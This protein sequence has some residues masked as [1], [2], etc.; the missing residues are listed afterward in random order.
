MIRVVK[1]DGREQDWDREK[2]IRAALSAGADG[3]TAKWVAKEVEVACPDKIEIEDL[4]QRVIDTLPSEVSTS[5]SAYKSERD[6]IR[7]M[8]ETPDVQA[9]SDYILSSKYAHYDIEASTLEDWPTCWRR[10]L[11]MHKR[12]YPQMAEELETMYENFVA[13]KKVL[14]AMRSLQFGGKAIEVNNTRMY[15]CWFG[16]CDNIKFFHRLFFILLSGGGVGYSVQKHHVAKLPKVLHV[17]A[18]SVYWHKVEDTIEGWGRAGKALLESYFETGEYVEFDFSGI[19]PENAWL[20]TTGGRAPGHVPLKTALENVRRVLEAFAGEQLTTFAAHRIAC[21][22]A[23]GVLSGGIRRS[24]LIALFSFDDAEM[25]RCKATKDWFDVYPELKM[26]NNSVIL[27]R[28][29]VT[30]EEFHEIFDW[31]RKFGEPGFVF[32]NDLEYGGNPC[33]EIGLFPRLPRSF[34]AC[35]LVEINCATVESPEDFY[36]RCEAA[37]II[38]TC[39]AGYTNL[40]Y[41]GVKTEEVVIAESLIGVG[42]CGIMDN[43]ICRRSEILRAGASVVNQTN[44]RIAD[45]IGIPH[46]ARTTTMKPGGTASLFLGCIACGVHTH[47]CRR[48]FRLITANPNEPVFQWFQKHNPHMC[49]QKPDGDWVIR[50]PVQVP[51]TAIVQDDMTSC[52]FLD[53]VFMVYD[54]WIKPGTVRSDIAPG[55]TNNISCTVPIASEGEWDEVIDHVWENRHRIAGQSYLRTYG[56]EP[57][58]FMPRTKVELT[59]TDEA[60]WNTIVRLY[61]HVNY[62]EMPPIVDGTFDRGSAC[63]GSKCD[64]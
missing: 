64:I 23:M 41:L 31:T 45:L 46:A 14:P 60:L 27:L 33:L 34:E 43:E 18:K 20:H 32:V 54:N 56:A 28:N 57:Y 51:S 48:Y 19:R 52:E 6:R 55:L 10:N 53:T 9:I 50:F 29:S 24:S 44:A 36:E 38:A 49:Q 25:M 3:K 59:E 15:N 1:R 2:I 61:K 12:K 4:H 30:K 63:E 42:L 35:N 22:F 7:A 8:R 62:Q 26:A 40:P 58:A 21:F 13:P 11:D 16:H 5:Y 47:P 39:Q 37:A 17:S